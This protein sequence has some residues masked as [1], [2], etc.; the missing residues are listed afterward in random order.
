[1]TNSEI[2]RNRQM[3]NLMGEIKELVPILDD[4]G[5]TDIFILQSGRIVYEHFIK[6]VIKTNIYYDKNK[7]T[8]IIN[9]IASMQDDEI[10]KHGVLETLLP[11]YDFR[12]EA[13]T[14]PWVKPN[15]EVAIRRPNPNIIPLE[16]WLK[17]KRISI[18]DYTLL[19]E[20]LENK[21]NIIIS[22]ATGSGKTTFLNTCIQKIVDLCPEERYLIIEDTPELRCSAENTTFFNIKKHE[23]RDAIEAAM[24][25]KMTRLIFGEVRSGIVLKELLEAWNTGHSGNLSTLHADSAASTMDRMTGMLEEYPDTKNRI[26][27][28]IHLIVHLE[29]KK[30]VEILPVTAMNNLTKSHDDHDL[31]ISK[32]NHVFIKQPEFRKKENIV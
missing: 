20:Y 32:G 22:G 24:R 17:E 19:N 13:I 16:Q 2:V 14:S 12:L 27:N 6:G 18:K 25:W 8:R 31:T 1:M 21:K 23:A 30:V 11:K 10:D 4:K 15:P 9:Y 3:E 29:N 7:V 5:V 28:V 26:K